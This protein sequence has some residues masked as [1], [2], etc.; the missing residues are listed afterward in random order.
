MMMEAAGLHDGREG[1]SIALLKDFISEVVV[2]P[3]LEANSLSNYEDNSSQSNVVD[4][5]D[6]DEDVNS[7]AYNHGTVNDHDESWDSNQGCSLLDIYNPD[8]SLSFL[9]DTPSEFLAGYNALCDEAVPID[10]LVSFSGRSEVFPLSESTAEANIGNEP[11]SSEGD[12]FFSNLE[13]LDWL[14]P[15]MA[16]EDL[17][18]LIDFTELN[19]H[20]ACLSKEQGTKKVT[21]V[22]D[23]DET[24][25]HS[26]VEQCDD[27]DFTFPVIFDMKDHMFYVRK[28]PHLH[29]FLQKMAEMFE[30]VIFTAS[31]SVYA[32]QLLDI[33]DPEK[34]MFS[35]RYFR[36][37]CVFT[38]TGY[39]KDLRVVGVDLAKVVIIDNTPQVFQLQVNNGIPID[40]WF[41]D[42][43]DEALL[44]LIPFLETL[45]FAD[46][47]R[48]IIAKKFGNKKDIAEIFQ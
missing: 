29:M 41:N 18:S 39:T 11:C 8:D 26:T 45:A 14:N 15:H 47:V 21:L 23:L 22:L 20:A 2:S 3:N 10:A 42:D 17:P 40:S 5:F 25:V 48:P 43:S 9:F 44:Q 4:Y 36:D 24:L 28:R 32:D 33:L 12:M 38:N 37:S 31:Q 16:E 13:V 35:R 7:A 1:T 19:S 46:D 34:K 30:I 6:K 27:A